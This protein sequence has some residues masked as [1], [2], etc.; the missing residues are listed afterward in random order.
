M[1]SV[2]RNRKRNRSRT[3][4]RKQPQEPRQSI[5]SAPQRWGRSQ[6][7]KLANTRASSIVLDRVAA[8]LAPETAPQ[9]LLK[10]TRRHPPVTQQAERGSPDARRS[11]RPQEEQEPP[12]PRKAM[13][14]EQIQL[15]TV[16]AAPKVQSSRLRRIQ[17]PQG[18]SEPT[19]P[20]RARHS[21]GA[22]RRRT[23]QMMP[24]PSVGIRQDSA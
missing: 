15:P 18:A 8:R 14:R 5:R 21:G 9:P 22:E 11:R 1:P 19:L 24:D 6:G 17:S 7:P 20:P 23:S 12:S 4:H 16:E 2:L 13:T 10:A 3:S